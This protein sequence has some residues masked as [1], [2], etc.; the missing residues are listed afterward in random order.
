M[1]PGIAIHG[2]FYQPPR[3]S[4]WTGRIGRQPSAA[5]DHDWNQRIAREC[6][7]PNARLRTLERISFNFGPTL[8][9]WADDEC[10]EL[11]RG[12]ALADRRGLEN[13][14]SAPAMAQVFS[15]PIAP[16]LTD[17]DRRTQVRWGIADF[18]RRYGR[19]PLGMWLP[20]CGVDLPSLRA[21][22]VEGIQFTILAPYQAS[23]ICDAAG[24]WHDAG[25][26]GVDPSQPARVDLGG[27]LSITV[28]FY[29]RAASQAVAFEGALH[30]AARFTDVLK[31]RAL[32]LPKSDLQSSPPPLLLV[33]TDGESYGHHAAGGAQT[34][35]HTLE[36]L[37][38]DGDV[39]ITTPAAWLARYAPNRRAEIR[40]QTAWS[41]AHGLERWKSDCGCR[42]GGGHQQW[43]APLRE[44]VETVTARIH[45]AFEREG[46][47]IFT[48]PWAARDA[49]A[50]LAPRALASHE[51]F[52]ATIRDRSRPEIL[53]RALRLA[54]ME[55][56]ML[57][58]HTSCGWFFDDV[59][60]LEP[61]QNL[62][63]LARAIEL[64]RVGAP[65]EDE[66][67]AILR[68]APSN[69]PTVGDAATVYRR[70]VLTEAIDAPALA[71]RAALR[72]AA[73]RD[74]RPLELGGSSVSAESWRRERL[75][76]RTF[77]SAIA[78][79]RD[80]F[81]GPPL[82]FAVAAIALPDGEC[83]AGLGPATD[84][85]RVERAAAECAAAFLSG[86][87]PDI[88]R[89]LANRYTTRGLHGM[90]LSDDEREE[91]EAA[92]R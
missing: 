60:G 46:S 33:A 83:F 44:A 85:E 73:F 79:I 17:R 25:E 14:G 18:E 12:V 63:F 28:F 26:H 92:R 19:R 29:D 11:A 80:A 47:V 59:S 62:R 82:A 41:C 89:A 78:R 81:D 68:R 42:S 51:P 5:P 49:C 3:E 37:G 67:M 90:D 58:A 87:T 27:G 86:R 56:Q 66:V 15:H 57:F 7:L 45:A 1:R 77:V 20:E 48:D 40:E 4:P 55:R 23:R 84:G 36:A 52:L 61:V 53:R 6:Y 64:S 22:A 24:K 54:E 13:Y 72:W 34:L 30:S 50:G 35:A 71:L 70:H 91:L 8:L 38:A 39:E 2:H 31:R 10:P 16:L 74:D 75:R 69:V 76:E 88:V 32:S 9:G 65:L 43:R 21:L